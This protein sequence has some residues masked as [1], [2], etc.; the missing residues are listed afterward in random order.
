MALC[1]EFNAGYGSLGFEPRLDQVGDKTQ[2][3]GRDVRRVRIA[4]GQRIETQNAL[5]VRPMKLRAQP[6]KLAK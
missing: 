1:R 6:A 2:P 5:F 3:N 4:L